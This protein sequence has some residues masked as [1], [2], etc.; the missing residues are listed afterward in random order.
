MCSKGEKIE[1][2]TSRSETSQ[3]CYQAIEKPPFTVFSWKLIFTAPASIWKVYLFP[4]VPVVSATVW[5]KD[6]DKDNKNSKGNF[7]FVIPF[8]KRMSSRFTDN[9]RTFILENEKIYTIELWI[10]VKRCWFLCKNQLKWSSVCSILH[11]YL[12]CSTYQNN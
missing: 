4:H 7:F 5:L 8:Q 1:I 10:L 12:L 11:F 2:G 9:S 3:N 6:Y